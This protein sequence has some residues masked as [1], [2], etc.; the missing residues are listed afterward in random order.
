[1]KDFFEFDLLPEMSG[2]YREDYIRHMGEDTQE[3]GV[4]ALFLS[5]EH[6][7]HAG[8]IHFLRKD[9]P[10]YCT[11]ETKVILE[12]MEEMGRGIFSEFCTCCE[13]FTFYKN[14]KGGLSRVTKKNKD[15]IK[16]RQYI[17]MEEGPLD[18]SIPGACAFIVYSNNE[19]A[20]YSGDLRFHGLNGEQSKAFAEKAKEAKPEY[21]ICEGTRIDETKKDSEKSVGERN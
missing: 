17:V 12:C 11:E 13:A 16:G 4:D 2:I 8:Y 1:L 7:D 18:H 10:I 9:I 21:F 15:F 14:K 6:M 5:H 3:R 20:V 19:T